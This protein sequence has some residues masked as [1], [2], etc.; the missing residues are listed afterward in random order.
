MRWLSRA[1]EAGEVEEHDGPDSEAEPLQGLPAASTGSITDLESNTPDVY[2]SR[3]LHLRVEHQSL[4]PRGYPPIPQ[5][6]KPQSLIASTTSLPA[7]PRES[8]TRLDVPSLTLSIPPEP[9][10]SCERCGRS[11]IAYELHMRCQQCNDGNYALCLQCWRLGRGCLNWYGFGH[12]AMT[13]WDRAVSSNAGDSTELAFPHILTGRRYRHVTAQEPP[14][15][16][17]VGAV[18]VKTSNPDVDL[19]IQTGFFCASCSAFAQDSYWVCDSCNDGEWGYC[20]FCV[21]AGRCCTHPLSLIGS[22]P[23][24]NVDFVSS[25]DS[26]PSETTP[27]IS[28]LT[29][30]IDCS[31]CISPIPP[32]ANHFHCPQCDDDLCASCYLKLVKRG[33]ISQANG[34]RG[35][36]RCLKNHRM[37]VVGF[38]FSDRGQRFIVVK[39][40]VGGHAL[41][42][43]NPKSASETYPPSGGGG[44]RMV[45][46]WSFWPSEGGDELALPRGAEIRECE[47]VDDEWTLGFYCGRQGLFPRCYCKD[48]TE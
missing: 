37:V 36:R 39:D 45:A 6:P 5:R 24:T 26:Q 13:L 43:S 38:E 16:D 47:N 11:N 44:L 18:V 33:Q 46:Q 21:R 28:P 17:R 48:V 41:D 32:T 19:Q 15:D 14:A 22:H 35:W 23:S 27:Q 4:N 1:V 2:A 42:V 20:A 29:C 7:I 31:I 10:V 8:S 30:Y 25:M 40:L 9:F 12:S 3:E 34:P